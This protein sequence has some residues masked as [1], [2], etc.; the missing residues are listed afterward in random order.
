MVQ[1]LLLGHFGQFQ[2]LWTQLGGQTLD[3]SGSGRHSATKY[4]ED[5]IN[6]GTW[7]QI[8]NDGA[9]TAKH[10]CR[11]DI[12]SAVCSSPGLKTCFVKESRSLNSAPGVEHSSC[13]VLSGNAVA[14]PRSRSRQF[15]TIAEYEDRLE[16]PH[17]EFQALY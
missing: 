12:E 16:S 2:A 14:T 1:S 4:R 13:V 5:P 8:L 9:K 3:V 11:E 6:A 15:S 7:H 10:G 17:R